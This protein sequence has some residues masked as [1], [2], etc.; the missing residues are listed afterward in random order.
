L[1]FCKEDL[2]FL[3][4]K[5]N[6]P[7]V[8]WH[9]PNFGV[10]FDDFMD[11]IEEA[12]PSDSI[13]FIAESSLSL[14][15]ERHK[16]RLKHNG[17]KALLPGIESWYDLGEKSKTGH[18]H[19][20]EKVRRISEH[21]NMIL[22]YIPY[23]QTNFVLGLDVDSGAEPFELT[24]RFVDLT[25]GAFPGYSLLSAFGEAAPLNY[26]YQQE[27]RVIPF[28]FHFLNNNGAMNLKPVNYSWPSFYKHVIDLTRY[29][30]SPRA[31]FRRLAATNAFIPRWLN[32]VRAVSS[33]GYGRVAHH[34]E[35][36]RM[37]EDDRQFRHFFERG[38]SEV[39]HFYV[40]QIQNYIGTMWHWLHKVDLY[41]V[42]KAYL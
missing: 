42:P 1:T 20:M 7:L 28:P 13:D 37:L 8:G 34:T 6:R 25:P 38:T 4:T 18:A 9:D 36:D 29:T 24:K 30:F 14:L 12:I 15:S 22:R 31:I 40:D 2:R 11:V 33:E 16:K 21:V 19:G 39:P 17:F 27:N 26:K 41:H 35:V 32:V 23:I 5:F 3:R 10:R